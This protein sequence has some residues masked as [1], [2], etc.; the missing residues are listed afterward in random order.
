MAEQGGGL[1]VIAGPVYVGRGVDGWTQTPAMAPMR[2]LYP[3]EFP[4]RLVAIDDN[5]Y[6]TRDPWPLELTREGREADFLWLGD[7]AAASRRAWADFPGVYSYYPLRRP[8]PGATVYARFSD[9]ATAQG[10]VQPVYWAGQFYGSGSVFYLGSGEMWRLR[11]IDTSL[12]DEFYTKL[13]RHV[14]QGRLLRGSSRGVLLVSQDHYM[15]GNTVEVRAQLTNARLDP[16]DV[17]SVAL[18][19]ILPGG[20]GADGDHTPRSEPGRGLLRAIPGP[21]RGYLPPG[22]A[23]ARKRQRTA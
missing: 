7:T 3:V 18:E 16:L 9:P 22:T 6:A 2:N 10:N 1:I 15:L 4:G 13:I 8:K 5:T 23:R 12:F 19:T 14:S 21:P 20:A 11:A 17:P